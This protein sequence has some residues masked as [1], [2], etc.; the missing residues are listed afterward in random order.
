VRELTAKD[1]CGKSFFL[2]STTTCH[3]P[4]VMVCRTR[5][6]KPDD[7]PYDDGT[8]P[9][10]LWTMIVYPHIEFIG[11]GVI[12]T[13]LEKSNMM[14]AGLARREYRDASAKLDLPP[15]RIWDPD[16]LDSP[17]KLDDLKR[18][19]ILLTVNETRR[20]TPKKLKTG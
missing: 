18:Q 15:D 8:G 3:A 20:H 11:S 14:W 5:P 7:D 6:D 12:L 16:I 2:E 9:T 17:R 19:K 10:D 13:G 4:A 1:V